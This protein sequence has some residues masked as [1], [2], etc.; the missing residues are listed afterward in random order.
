[1]HFKPMKDKIF[2]TELESGN[3]MTNGGILLLDDNLKEEGIRPRWGK[4]AFVGDDIDYVSVGEWVLVP[5]GRW[6]VGLTINHDGKDMR[7]WMIDND[8]ILVI[9]DIPDTEIPKSHS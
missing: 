3:R 6:T 9:S 1:M 8:A 7:I 5:H 4:V 2:V